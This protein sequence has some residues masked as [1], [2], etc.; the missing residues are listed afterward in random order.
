M[1]SRGGGRTARECEIKWMGDRYPSINHTQWSQSEISKCKDLIDA[2][3]KKYG[4]G[5]AVDWVW[6]VNELK[7]TS[8][9][10]TS[11]TLCFLMYG[12]TNRTP[13]DCMRHG[14]VRKTHVWTPEAD[15]TLMEAVKTYGLNN[16]LLGIF[17]VIG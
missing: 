11:R 16:W 14:A 4:H 15:N 2:Y 13:L 17:R 1:A 8:G 7:V 9:E 6:V 3:R 5:Q 12:Q 10:S